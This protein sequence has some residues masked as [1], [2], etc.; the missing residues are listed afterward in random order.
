[1]CIK[2]IKELRPVRRIIRSISARAT[3]I[4]IFAISCSNIVAGGLMVLIYQT[5]LGEKLNLNFISSTLIVLAFSY[6]SS[7]VS[8]VLISR[9]LLKPLRKITNATAEIAAGNFDVDTSGIITKFNKDTEVGSLV[10]GF[11][12]MA[13]D[14]R[15]TEM[16]RNDFIHNFSHE[17]K[18]PIISIQGFAKQLYRGNLTQE[19]TSEFAKII[20]DESDRLTHMA[21]NVLL[22]TKIDN[23]EI[24]SDKTPFSLDEQLRECVLLFEE[25]WSDKN[26]NLNLDLDPITYTQNQDLL[27]HVWI[28]LIGNAIKFSG[29]NGLLDIQCHE[30]N[31]N[32]WITVKDSGIGMDEDTMNHIFDKFYQGDSSHSTPGNGLG[33][34]LA[35]RIIEMM[36]GRISVKSTKGS[37]TTFSV[38][39]PFED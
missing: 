21:S 32:I 4:L 29:D 11:D 1:M 36:N 28:N 31:G 19:Q 33:L 16:F 5:R 30:G 3:F 7:A 22:L 6:I 15:S 39:L 10:T 2:S 9:S 17:F 13:A 25:Q 27:S 34:P 8:S 20:M 37:G 26:L 35:K 38:T 14:L 12:R 24:V 23:Q 18:T